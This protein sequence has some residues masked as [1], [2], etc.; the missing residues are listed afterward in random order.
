MRYVEDFIGAIKTRQ[1]EIAS[2]LTAGQAVDYESYKHL[3]GHHAG[4]GEA[5]MILDGL[6]KEDDDGNK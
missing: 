6:L 4:L 2:S 3:V 1:A 5:L